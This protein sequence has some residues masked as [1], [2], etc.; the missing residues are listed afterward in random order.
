[1]IIKLY[2]VQITPKKPPFSSNDSTYMSICRSKINL[3][4]IFNK[5]LWPLLGLDG[6]ELPQ[7]Y[8]ATTRRHFKKNYE[9]WHCKT[10]N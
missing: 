1:M 8:R 3:L 6:V 9:K 4:F 7:D 2:K 5:T 10:W